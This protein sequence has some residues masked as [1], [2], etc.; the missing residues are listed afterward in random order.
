MGGLT[1]GVK[2]KDQKT[3]LPPKPIKREGQ[4]LRASSFRGL[5]V[6]DLIDTRVKKTSFY[7]KPRPGEGTEKIK[8]E[9]SLAETYVSKTYGHGWM[10][11]WDDR[12]KDQGTLPLELVV[13]KKELESKPEIPKPFNEMGE[14]ED[15][16][17]EVE[18]GQYIGE[19]LE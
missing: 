14:P 2:K 12:S 8:V 5:P 3:E 15:I 13:K 17:F 6:W 16:G 19:N 9:C 4:I 10:I 7:R 18:E 11:D 1:D